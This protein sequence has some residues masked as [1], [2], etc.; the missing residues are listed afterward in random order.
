MHVEASADLRE[1]VRARYAMHSAIVRA[2][3]PAR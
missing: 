1:D 3:K 2:I